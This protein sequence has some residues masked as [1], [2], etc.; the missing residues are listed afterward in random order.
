MEQRLTKIESKDNKKYKEIKKIL[1]NRNK[2]KYNLFLAEGEKFFEKANLCK[3]L[4]INE[5]SKEHIQEKYDLKP[6]SEIII[7]KD[8]LFSEISSQE[9]SQ[10]VLFLMQKE[11]KKLEDVYG[12]IIVLDEVQDPGNL[13]TILRNMVALSYKNIFL[14]KNCANI[15]H[16]KVVRA[17]MGAVFNVNAFYLEDEK[18]I[19]FLKNRKYNIYATALKENSKDFREIKTKNN[20]Y[21]FGNEG[22]GV[23]KEL[24]SI[25]D[26]LFLIPMLGSVNSFNV[27]IANAIFLYKMREIENMI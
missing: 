10:G 18:L 26:D 16:A 9:N 6:F 23:R 25:C 20:A 15:Y 4:I 22:H 2:D 27:A 8:S 13:G 17:S 19:E 24:L 12:D 11:E 7:L 3:I 21:I 14:T 1:K 5:I